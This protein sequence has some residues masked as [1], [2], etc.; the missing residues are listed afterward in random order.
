MKKREIV[1]KSTDYNNIIQNGKKVDNLYFAL[2]YFPGN[3]LEEAKFGFAI[4]K[5]ITTAVQRNKLKRQIKEI[6]DKNKFLFPKGQN[7]IIM[8]KK[9]L[10]TLK[11]FEIEK[12]LLNVIG[13]VKK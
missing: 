8:I 2:F 1:K 6:I 4:S 5:K 9:R 13:K 11:Y 3:N 7:Y 10:L 12:E